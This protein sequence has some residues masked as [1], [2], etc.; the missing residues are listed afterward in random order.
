L[1]RNRG[2]GRQFDPLTPPRQNYAVGDRPRSFEETPSLNQLSFYLE[3]R[4]AGT[5]FGRNVLAQAGFRFDN[6]NPTSPVQGEL[7]T[8][9]APRLNATAELFNGV[10]LRGGY[11]IT[12]KSPT[13]SFL[14][15]DPRFF[16]L[17]GFNY[18]PPNPAERLLIITTRVVQPDVSTARLYR[19]TKL[20]GGIDISLKKFSASLTVFREQTDG[21]FGTN[22]LPVALSFPRFRAT[23]TPSGRPPVIE[24]T[25]IDTFIA[26][27][28]VPANTRTITSTGAELVIDVPEWSL[29]RTSLNLTGS[30]IQSRELD[31]ALF[32]NVNDLFGPSVPRQISVFQSG[33]GS[34]ARQMIT[35]LRFIT[36]VPELSLVMSFLA[37]T[38]WTESSRLLNR[39]A[40]P[41]G[42]FDRSGN[43][44]FFPNEPP[45]PTQPGIEVTRPALWLFQFR[46]TKELESGIR[47]SVYANNAFASRPLF[48]NTVTRRTEQRNP[49]LFFGAEVFY[50]FR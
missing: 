41:V 32:F 27:Y 17:V 1:D 26:V 46:L 14:N 37:Q 15:P 7:G 38:V 4:I 19:S 3:N 22:R 50:S 33:G 44:V 31:N 36:R 35:S 13:L 9:I 24:Q 12:A 43:T 20:D 6:V 48:L 42:V 16:D 39:S 29:I 11:G 47:F 25:L 30:Y 2:S 34:E 28:D 18:F 23:E 49:T 8:V 5:V 21:A 40:R 10:W 45:P